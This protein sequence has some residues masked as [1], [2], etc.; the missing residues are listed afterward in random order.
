MMLLKECSTR[1][2]SRLLFYLSLITFF[3]LPLYFLFS[4]GEI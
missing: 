4:N 1:A 3:C 2:F